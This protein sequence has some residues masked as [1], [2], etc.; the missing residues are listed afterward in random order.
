MVR[1]LLAKALRKKHFYKE[2]VKVEEI[3]SGGQSVPVK[4]M[5]D[6]WLKWDP[7]SSG[8]G[9]VLLDDMEKSLASSKPVKENVKAIN[10]TSNLN[11]LPSHGF[12]IK[13]LMHAARAASETPVAD[14]LAPTLME[15][16]GDASDE[17]LDK[18]GLDTLHEE[19]QN[20]LKNEG[21]LSNL[22]NDHRVVELPEGQMF[23]SDCLDSEV[24]LGHV[25]EAK[26]ALLPLSRHDQV[27]GLEDL[28][29]LSLPT[30]NA[31]SADPEEMI[32]T[33]NDLEANHSDDLEQN[34]VASKTQSQD[35]HQGDCSHGGGQLHITKINTL[36]TN[37]HVSE[38]LFNPISRSSSSVSPLVPAVEN[39]LEMGV[40]EH[41]GN[42]M[43]S[44]LNRNGIDIMQEHPLADG[45]VDGGQYNKTTI[46][47]I[48][49]GYG[50]P[51]EGSSNVTA[52]FDEPIIDDS[53]TELK[54]MGS[55]TD[56]QGL[57]ISQAGTHI[58][59]CF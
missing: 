22:S 29:L 21:N 20:L 48:K 36:A 35:S 13:D 30:F 9:D 55:V 56:Y 42:T 50:L 8:Q 14:K 19:Q 32:Q 12:Q 38:D 7:I 52:N 44:H 2:A 3:P 37:N 16:E 47:F 25:P 26:L 27:S 46:S 41:E 43:D 5:F 49:S 18:G 24:P 40:G 51:L 45:T 54:Q 1:S 31:E 15:T 57:A 59:F 33:S 39:V 34:I 11:G 4:S 28:P 58:F 17:K 6:D 10:F 23:N 53:M